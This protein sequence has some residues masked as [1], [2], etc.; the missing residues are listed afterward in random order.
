MIVPVIF[1]SSFAYNAHCIHHGIRLLDYS[2]VNQLKKNNKTQGQEKE[3][4][5]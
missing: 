2:P 5:E 4:Y 1:I 3:E